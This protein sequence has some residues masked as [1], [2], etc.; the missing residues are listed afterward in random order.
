MLALSES[1]DL[2]DVIRLNW[3]VISKSSK[4]YCSVAAS[5]DLSSFD[6]VLTIYSTLDNVN[7]AWP[8][9]ISSHRRQAFGLDEWARQPSRRNDFD[10]VGDGDDGRW[11]QGLVLLLANGQ[12]S[13]R[14]D[15]LFIENQR[16]L[17]SLC[18][19]FWAS[20]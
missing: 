17:L 19:L 14:D 12:T 20:N 10:A 9:R 13:G 7:P 1:V 3:L 11:F 18:L 15:D 2:V 4:G 16:L 8:V 6:D 5:N